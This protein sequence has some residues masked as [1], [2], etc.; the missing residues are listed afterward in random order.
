MVADGTGTTFKAY[1]TANT[2]AVDAELHFILNN[3]STDLELDNLVVRQV[4]GLVNN[5]HSNE[6]VIAK[7]PTNSV[8]NISCGSLGIPAPFC[9]QYVDGTNTAVTFSLSVNPYSSKII[10]W[11]N[12]TQILNR[13]SGTLVPSSGSIPNG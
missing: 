6:A 4:V 7:N 5:N 13:P 11:N 8:T 3:S 10:F 1:V 12:A 2:N 9:G